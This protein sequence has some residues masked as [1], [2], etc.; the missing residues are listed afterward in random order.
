MQPMS[1]PSSEPGQAAGLLQRMMC[2]II[3]WSILGSWAL[4][5]A[6]SFASADMPGARAIGPYYNPFRQK[7]GSKY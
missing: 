2:E 1:S 7:L 4:M 5:Q 3:P 6:F